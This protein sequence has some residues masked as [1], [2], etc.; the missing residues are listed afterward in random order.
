V[1]DI[2][3]ADAF[4]LTDDIIFGCNPHSYSLSSS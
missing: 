2:A 3:N 1:V 4:G